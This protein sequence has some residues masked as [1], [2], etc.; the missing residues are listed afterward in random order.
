MASLIVFLVFLV[1]FAVRVPVTTAIRFLALLSLGLAILL[2]II[3]PAISFRL[4]FP[5][6]R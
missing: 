2:A 1:L 4:P 3:V 5:H 6:H